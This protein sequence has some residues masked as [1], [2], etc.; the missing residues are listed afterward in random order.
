M[1][2]RY[3]TRGVVGG[4]Y[5]LFDIIGLEMTL[6]ERVTQCVIIHSII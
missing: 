1:K 4:A 6:N 3:Q 2:H 5:K